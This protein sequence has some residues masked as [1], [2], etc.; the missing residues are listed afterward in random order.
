MHGADPTSPT[1]ELIHLLSSNQWK[2]AVSR[3][4]LS[5]SKT[6]TIS[7][8]LQHLSLLHQGISIVSA[9]QLL[10][11]RGSYMEFWEKTDDGEIIFSAWHKKKNK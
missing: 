6:E 1:T 3:Q 11:I 2:L 4:E 10:N 7:E 9:S 8:V 5:C